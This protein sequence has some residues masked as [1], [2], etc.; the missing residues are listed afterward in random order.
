M[1]TTEERWSLPAERRVALAAGLVARVVPKEAWLEEAKGLATEIAKRGPV[2]TRLAKES[3]DLLLKN[4][5]RILGAV[6]NK[7]D[8]TKAQLYGLN[9]F[10]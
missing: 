5:A 3:V 8:F 7:V 4:D 10:A 1:S 2:G 6:L 9:T